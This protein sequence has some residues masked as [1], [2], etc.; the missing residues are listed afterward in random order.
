V[1]A[2]SEAARRKSFL[3]LFFKKEHSSLPGRDLLL[4]WRED[5][6]EPIRCSWN[7]LEMRVSETAVIIQR[8]IA[9]DVADT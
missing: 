1:I 5:I 8:H 4:H 2:A 3:V 7:P 6:V 9:V